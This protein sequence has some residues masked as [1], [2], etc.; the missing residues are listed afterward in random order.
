M[1]DSAECVRRK[2]ERSQRSASGLAPA[3]PPTTGSPLC[4]ASSGSSDT[5]TSVCVLKPLSSP[6]C[7]MHAVSAESSMKKTHSQKLTDKPGEDSP[8]RRKRD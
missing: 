5:D 3:P 4:C 7:G 1:R 6:V 2:G 8:L